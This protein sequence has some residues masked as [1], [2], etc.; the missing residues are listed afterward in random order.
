MNLARK[1]ADI[2]F[3]VLL[4]VIGL[5]LIRTERFPVFYKTPYLAL[6]VM[7]FVYRCFG[8]RKKKA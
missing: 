8:K 1:I 5:L 6:L 2:S 4:V 7:Y 3:M